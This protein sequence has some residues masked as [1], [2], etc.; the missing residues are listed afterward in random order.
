MTVERMVVKRAVMMV[1]L[2]V[3]VKVALTAVYTVEKMVVKTA[4]EMVASRD[5]NRVGQKVE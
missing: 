4:D 3:D 5:E 1:A 2:L